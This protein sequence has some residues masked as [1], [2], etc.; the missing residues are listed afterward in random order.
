M[1]SRNSSKSAGSRPPALEPIMTRRSVPQSPG[2]TDS[3]PMAG[4]SSGRP[5][6]ESPSSAS[7]RGAQIGTMTTA[8]L[9]YAS[10]VLR[11]EAEEELQLHREQGLEQEDADDTVYLYPSVKKKDIKKVGAFAG[12]FVPTCENMWG[13]LIFLRFYLIVGNAGVSWALVAVFLSFS[14]AFL[15]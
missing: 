10:A 5:P 11:Q 2:D 3:G 7:D 14:M 4:P 13:V 15:T 12:V 9:N 8:E 1:A 6:Q